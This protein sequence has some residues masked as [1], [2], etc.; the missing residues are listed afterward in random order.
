MGIERPIYVG[1]GSIWFA[2]FQ[3][4]HRLLKARRMVSIEQDEIIFQRA[5]FNRPWRTVDV[6]NGWSNAVL[7]DLLNEQ[8]YGNAPWVVW[9]DIDRA[10]DED[11]L[12]ELQ[13]LAVDLPENSVLLTTFTAV[14]TTYGQP[15]D[16]NARLKDIF[17]EAIEDRPFASAKEAREQTR[18]MSV[19]SQATLDAVVSHTLKSGRKG[20]VVPCARLMYKDGM[21]MVT[22]GWALPTQ[23]NLAAV[24]RLVARPSWSAMDD[25]P[26]ITP[27]LTHKEILALQA[28]MPSSRPLSE[29]SVRRL[30]FALPDD[31]R[32]S[33]S[34]HYLRYPVYS[35]L[36]R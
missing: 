9:L 17:G 13:Q 35:Q 36:A 5:K 29:A 4:A 7:P 10:I 34:K 23:T 30:G 18:M 14:D 26:I 3:L 28:R 31:A 24:R 11:H 19:L 15:A 12:E 1:L 6:R 21:P 22:V 8:M 16:R 27:P 32:T 25:D 20:G 2:D 33:Y